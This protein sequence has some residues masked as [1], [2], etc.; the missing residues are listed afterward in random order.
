M[1]RYLVFTISAL[2]L[3]AVFQNCG[4]QHSQGLNSESL[5]AVNILDIYPYY[6]AKPDFFESVQLTDVID[7]GSSWKYQFVASA[8]Y[9]DDPDHEIDVRITF[10][11]ISNNL[12]CPQVNKRVNRSNNHIQIDNCQNANFHSTILIQVYA[13][14]KGVPTFQKVN[15]YSF[16]IE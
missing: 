8:T 14:L 5:K 1:K 9:I 13:K 15:E 7:Q 6:D 4:S 2:C 16:N 12:I 11:D 3:L 10:K